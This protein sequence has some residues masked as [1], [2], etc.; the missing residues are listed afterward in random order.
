MQRDHPILLLRVPPATRRGIVLILIAL[1][2]A[3]SPDQPD[4][5]VNTPPLEPALTAHFSL[6]QEGRTGAARVRIRRGMDEAGWTAQGFFLMGLSY[7]HDHR[8][9]KAAEWFE[10][11]TTADDV[12][13]PAQHFLGWARFYLGQ[14][15]AAAAAFQSHLLMAP[16]EG[17]SH[18][19]LGLIAMERGDLVGAERRL[20]MAIDLQQD[21]GPGR[22]KALARLGD[23]SAAQGRWMKAEDLLR[24][25]VELDGDLYEAWYRRATALRRLGRDE[26]A[27]KAMESFERARARVRPDLGFPE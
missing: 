14:V 12:Y 3:C 13:P 10:R 11:S 17:D 24:Q 23:V 8:Y 19:A 9:A 20:T 27:N 18:F 2:G 1:L 21:D 16:M 5:E 4:Q 25:S 15:D 6:I 22:A 26:D 7:H